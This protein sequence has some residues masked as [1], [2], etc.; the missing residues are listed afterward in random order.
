M[1][2]LRVKDMTEKKLEYLKRERGGQ[3]EKVEF[4]KKFKNKKEYDGNTLLLIS[5]IKQNLTPSLLKK[6]YRELN[7]NNPTYGHCYVATETLYHLLNNNNFKPYYAKDENNIT[8]WWLQDKQK[9]ILDVTADQYLLK[10]KQPPYSK[11]KRGNFLT[12]KPSKRSC[13]LI[14]K[15]DYE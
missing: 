6:E 10:D 15:I 13:L 8:H 1:F 7:K 12:K 9:I 11:G 14:K 2:H 5:K 4:G 3:Q